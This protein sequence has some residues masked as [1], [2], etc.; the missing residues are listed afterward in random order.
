MEWWQYLTAGGAVS[1]LFVAV[2]TY[3]RTRPAMRLAELK[4]ED[5]LWA[6]ISALEQRTAELER[7]LVKEQ[8]KRGD[9]E[10]DLANENANFDAFLL[11]IEA[12]PDKV[13]EQIPKIREMRREHRERMALKRGAREGVAIQ[14][15]GQ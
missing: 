7:L 6:R 1:A 12:N 5:A 9:V 11:L 14:E 15:A 4:G 2:G 13:I 3:L 8:T 10:H